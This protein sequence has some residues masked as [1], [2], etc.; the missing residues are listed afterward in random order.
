MF[1]ALDTNQDLIVE[2]SELET[3]IADQWA[4]LAPSD[5]VSALEYA[6]W[7]LHVFGARDTMPSFIAFDHDLDGRF[8]REDFAK[9][10][11]FEFARLD[12]DHSGTLTRS[13]LLFRI[14]SPARGSAD[15]RERPRGDGRSRPPR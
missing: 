12:T 9:R 6:T 1:A 2:A 10:L 15:G 8:S 14:A 11:R 7:S 5:R 13:E 3:G 4:R